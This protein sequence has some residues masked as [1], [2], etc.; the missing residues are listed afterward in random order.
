[1]TKKTISIFI[2]SLALGG[3]AQAQS[4]VDA[5]KDGLSPLTNLV[6]SEKQA[7]PADSV[8]KK[9]TPKKN[10]QALTLKDGTVYVGEMKGKRPHG[11][12]KAI[13]KNG[14]IYEGGFIKGLR[15]GKG[16]Y[17]FKDGERYVGE[18]KDGHQHGEG[19]YTFSDGR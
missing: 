5:V 6:N 14:D 10:V 12:G 7:Q 16:E 8:D 1:M 3:T 2:L 4:F 17:R 13:Y 18:F 11:Q 9:N 19:V 15:N